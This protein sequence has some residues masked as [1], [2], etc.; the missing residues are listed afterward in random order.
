[1]YKE[2][3]RITLPT[4]LDEGEKRKHNEKSNVL[5]KEILKQRI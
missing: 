4:Y 2:D 1:M 5:S 3:D